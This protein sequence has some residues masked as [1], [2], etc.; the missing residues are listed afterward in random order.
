[1]LAYPAPVYTDKTLVIKHLRPRLY[2]QLQRLTEDGRHYQPAIDVLSLARLKHPKKCVSLLKKCV[3]KI[4]SQGSCLHFDKRDI[5]L[6]K[7]HDGDD[8]DCDTSSLRSAPGFE[9]VLSH[10]E[11]LTERKVLAVL[12]PNNKIVTENG[13]AWTAA[14]RSSGSFEF[15]CADEHGV[16]VVARW[17]STKANNQA[18]T[19]SSTPTSV[20]SSVPESPH[21]E[22]AFSFSLIDPNSRRHAVLATLSPSNLHIKDTYHRPIRSPSGGPEDSND[23]F[24]VVD[25]DTKTL[26]L[27]TAVWLNLYLGWSLS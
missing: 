27:A 15:T 24:C 17:V 10:L 21:V 8:S 16:V 19:G 7:T 2:L 11:D 1:M 13:R 4:K 25:E 6:A 22:A 18:S 23:R 5:L 12:R 20:Q 3:N 26:I 9:R 14:K